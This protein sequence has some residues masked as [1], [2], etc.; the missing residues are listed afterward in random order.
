MQHRN[1]G[2]N[3]EQVKVGLQPDTLVLVI[4]TFRLKAPLKILLLRLSEHLVVHKMIQVHVT[5]SKS[6]RPCKV[7]PL[8]LEFV[9]FV[10]WVGLW[11]SFS[12]HFR[13]LVH[14]L[15]IKQ[16]GVSHQAPEVRDVLNRIVQPQVVVN[17]EVTLKVRND[18][19]SRSVL[20]EV[21][22]L[23]KVDLLL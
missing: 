12:L 10:I 14:L 20:G 11:H 23:M 17:L 1:D 7:F 19:I 18:F 3:R 21:H 9:A 13:N 16:N 4:V 22:Y 8:H 6:H 2:S 5:I 15:R